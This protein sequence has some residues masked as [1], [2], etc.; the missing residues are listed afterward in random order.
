LGKLDEVDA[1]ILSALYKDASISI[2]KL[3]KDLG[4][5]LSV[6]YSRIR[7]LMRR[8]IIQQFTLI[9]N[10]GKLGYPASAIVGVNLDPKQREQ[11][12]EELSRLEAVRQLI[13]VTGRFDLF[14]NLKSKSIEEIHRIV[15]E[16]IG[17][18]AGVNQTE[19]FVELASKRPDINFKLA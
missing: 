12:I 18:I 14:V 19:M 17:K 3:S 9:I 6:T 4:L 13:E 5:N 2:P 15:S 11:A 7:R 16:V 10:E 1:R 8:G